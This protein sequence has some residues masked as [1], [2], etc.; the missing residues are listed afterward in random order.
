MPARCRT[1]GS[2]SRASNTPN[3]MCKASHSSK[4]PG[5]M[6]VAMKGRSPRPRASKTL[7]VS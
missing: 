3:A 5:P 1:T 2:S 6:V 7:W 4:G